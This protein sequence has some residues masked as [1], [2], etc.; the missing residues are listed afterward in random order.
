MTIV[1]DNESTQLLRNTITKLQQQLTESNKKEM[2]L[3]HQVD[4]IHSSHRAEMLQVESQYLSTIRDIETR[5]TTE[6]STVKTENET[7]RE[8]ERNIYDCRM[9]WI[10]YKPP[11]KNYVTRKNS[12]VNV[13]KGW[14]L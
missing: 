4:T 2:T 6:L 3:V 1:K 5:Y 11:K 13:V 12:Y 14:I 9:K 10:Y 8:Y 7:L